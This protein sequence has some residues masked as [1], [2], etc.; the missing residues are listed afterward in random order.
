MG[1]EFVFPF[2]FLGSLKR[3]CLA[4][5][6][7]WHREVLPGSKCSR[8]LLCRDGLCSPCAEFCSR[9]WDRNSTKVVGRTGK[10][11][12]SRDRLCSVG[13]NS[14]EEKLTTLDESLCLSGACGVLAMPV[15]LHGV[16]LPK[17]KSLLCASYL[18]DLASSHMLV[19]KIKPCMSQYKPH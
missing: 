8:V 19:S 6:L 5:L 2:F 14:M 4:G 12:A 3:E 15:R 13:K 10:V 17:S 7:V 16:L 1:E 9:F 11:V 18:V